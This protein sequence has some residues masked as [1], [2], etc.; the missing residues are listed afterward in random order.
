MAVA[1]LTTLYGA[2]IASAFALPI[3]AKLSAL[4]ATERL[5]KLLILESVAAI[6]EGTNPR[7]LKQMLN[8]FLPEEQRDDGKS[9]KKK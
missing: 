1:L 8:A 3:S 9:K 7:I 6:Q 4:S 5:N 2:V